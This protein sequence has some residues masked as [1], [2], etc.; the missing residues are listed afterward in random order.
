MTRSLR[1]PWQQQAV[2]LSLG[3]SFMA[4]LVQDLLTV[5]IIVSAQGEVSLSLFDRLS[6]T[7]AAG[8]RLL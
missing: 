1:F 8:C 5:S 4:V 7:Q 2:I 3:F 6:I